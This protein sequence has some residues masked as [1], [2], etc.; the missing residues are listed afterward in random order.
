[1]DHVEFTQRLDDELLKMRTLLIEKNLAY[2]NSALDPI[3]CFSKAS[4]L[5]QIHV[6]MDDNLS[7]MM[8]GQAAGEDCPKDLVGYWFLEQ[9]CKG[10]I[11][12]QDGIAEMAKEHKKLTGIG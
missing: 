7:R 11:A 4:P 12:E 5:E 9:I 1:M 10:V 2:G 8:K 6:R 3:R